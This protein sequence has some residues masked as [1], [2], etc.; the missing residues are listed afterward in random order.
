MGNTSS[1]Q[2]HDI[3]HPPYVTLNPW[4]SISPVQCQ[5][6]WKH[7]RTCGSNNVLLLSPWMQ[8]KFFPSIFIAVRRQCAG[9]KCVDVSTVRRWVWQF[10]QEVGEASLCDKARLGRPLTATE[11]SHQEWGK[12]WFEKTVK[13]NRKWESLKKE[14]A[15]LSA[16][17]D[18]E[19]F[20]S[21]GTVKIGWK[22]HYFKGISG[23]FWR[24]RRGISVV[25]SDRW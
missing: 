7:V 19:K 3:S 23:P 8:K 25:D 17:S 20:V 4:V 5:S 18:S 6:K 16:F 21:V 11:K 1:T 9:D 14:W 13:S 24:G 2:S 10:K 22:S 15:T 12:K